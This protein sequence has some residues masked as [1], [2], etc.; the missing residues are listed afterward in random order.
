MWK[1]SR[2]CDSDWKWGILIWRSQ[3]QSLGEVIFKLSLPE[4][5][6]PASST[7]T[8]KSSPDRGKNQQQRPQG[9]SRCGLFDT[10]KSLHGENDQM[11]SRKKKKSGQDP[12]G[13]GFWKLPVKDQEE[14]YL[15]SPVVWSLS[16]LPIS[17]VKAA[18]TRAIES[19]SMAEFQKGLIYHWMC[20]R[21][22]VWPSYC[23]II[24][25]FGYE[26]TVK[27]LRTLKEGN[28]MI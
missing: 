5:Q 10:E 4:W 22:V 13:S 24:E 27:T 3:G 8:R 1:K 14:K 21:T 18:A 17:G 16:Q 26:N 15:T 2:C 19:R 28:D 11:V 7:M 20:T 6:D 25:D 23:R 9:R 12:K